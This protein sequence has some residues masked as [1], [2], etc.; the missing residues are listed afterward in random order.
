MLTVDALPNEIVNLPYNTLIG[1]LTKMFTASK[2]VPLQL[3]GGR[4]T[5]Y[6][7]RQ[8]LLNLAFADNKQ[9]IIPT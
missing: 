6:A 9:S 8:L 3:T 7:V 4:R 1:I 2:H 5:I